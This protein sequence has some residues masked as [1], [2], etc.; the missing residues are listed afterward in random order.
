VSGVVIAG[1]LVLAVF[2]AWLGCAGF[3]RLRGPL[4]RLHCVAF[5]NVVSGGALTLAAFAQ[6][7][8]SVRVGKLVLIL[9]V[10]LLAGAASS[11]AIGRALTVR[12]AAPDRDEQP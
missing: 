8:L 5:V 2:G 4:D 1:L 12:A 9:G 11:H 10:S 6:D 7:G 3:A